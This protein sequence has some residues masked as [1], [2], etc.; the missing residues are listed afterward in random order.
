MKKTMAIIGATEQ[1][2]KAAIMQLA[3]HPGFRF[4]LLSPDMAALDSLTKTLLQK[5]PGAEIEPMTCTRDASW[6]ADIIVLTVPEA[7]EETIAQLIKE[8]VTGKV[9]IHVK[10]NDETSVLK[11]LLP[12]SIVADARLEELAEV[13][14]ERCKA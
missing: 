14:G 2:G 13:I 6:E 7:E 11:T 8:V 4:L 9:V 1:K 10:E 5:F 3:S 12:H